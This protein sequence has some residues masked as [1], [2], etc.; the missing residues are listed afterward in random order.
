MGAKDAAI[1]GM[2]IERGASATGNFMRNLE[3]LT[4]AT[5]E[6]VPGGKVEKIGEIN[7]SYVLGSG[8]TR[9]GIVLRNGITYIARALRG[10][11]VKILGKLEK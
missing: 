6:L 4:E 5:M 2:A 1:F 11:P 8:K 3:L 10:R 7:G 9:Y